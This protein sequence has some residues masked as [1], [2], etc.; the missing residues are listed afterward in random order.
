M[1]VT[2]ETPSGLGRRMRVEIPEDRISGE[3]QKRL[4]KLA[5]DV[6]L[7]GFRQGK[8]PIKVVKQRFGSQIRNEVLGE[9]VQSTFVDA[10]EQENLRPAG[11]PNI[12]PLDFKPGEGL[13]YTAAFDVYPEITLP[14]LETLK[15]TRPVAELGDA[16]VEKM[17]ETLRKQRRNWTTV[18]RAATATD[19]VVIDFEGF[20]DEK[21]VENAT[22]KDF[23]VELDGNRMIPGFEAG[24][25]GSLA[26]EERTLSLNFPETY[27]AAELAG[28]AVEFKVT[29]Q[30]VEEPSL[31]ELDDEFAK[32]F[33]VS[34]GGI[35]KLQTEVR[36]NM[37]RELTDVLRNK[38]KQAAL[39]TLLEAQS[40]ELPEALVKEECSAALQRQLHEL[41]HSGVDP[42]E[43]NLT[44]EMFEDQARN[45]VTLGLLLAELIKKNDIKPDAH[46]VRERIESLASTYEQPEEVVNWYYGS[47]E[48][49]QEI[50]TS[51][52]EDQVVDWI[53]ERA[54]VT[55]ET[56]P[57][58]DLMN[59]GQTS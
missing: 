4:Q 53:L 23:P 38:T 2:V 35:E 31:P 7:P 13:S 54:D 36:E 44:T 40:I 42:K 10:L 57:F 25:V 8:V 28:R 6:R 34:E 1:Q 29:V 3:I 32:G 41:E 52:L 39:D 26:N 50:E 33:G 47:K 22:G 30:Q 16:D 48:R 15:I 11:S 18:E 56:T 20:M 17:I 58:D 49:L 12:E 46:K 45:R 59:P 19:R 21:P 9:L 27:H 14:E 37:Q 24:L 5:G 43:A 51:V 55:L